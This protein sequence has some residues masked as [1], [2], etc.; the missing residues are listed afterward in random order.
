M[1]STVLYIPGGPKSDTVLVTEFH[2]FLDALYLQSATSWVK[3]LGWAE[4]CNFLTDS[5]KFFKI[6]IPIPIVPFRS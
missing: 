6:A 2:L 4:S 1:H 3:K 5:W